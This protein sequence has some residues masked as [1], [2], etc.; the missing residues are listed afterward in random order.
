MRIK[1]D[2]QPMLAFKINTLAQNSCT[3]VDMPGHAPCSLVEMRM[4]IDQPRRDDS[5]AAVFHSH[6][7]FS[8]EPPET[9]NLSVP[10]ED[11]AGFALPSAGR[12][13]AKDC[14]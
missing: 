8:L 4:C 13:G 2:F 1:A 14:S 3:I 10:D 5:T 11:I 9:G 6:S 12:C 7:W